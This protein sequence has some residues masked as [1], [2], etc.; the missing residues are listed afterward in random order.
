MKRPCVEI[1]LFTRR[2][3]ACEESKRKSTSGGLLY[4]NSEIFH[5]PEYR[6]NCAQGDKTEPSHVIE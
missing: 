3:V 4:F 6:L 1:A 2:L 5:F